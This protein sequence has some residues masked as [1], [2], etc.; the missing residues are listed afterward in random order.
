MH[1]RILCITSGRPLAPWALQV[2]QV[3]SS[4]PGSER[5]QRQAFHRPH[6]D[7]RSHHIATPGPVR[8]PVAAQR[9]LPAARPQ[10]SDRSRPAPWRRGCLPAA[11]AVR[12]P[13][14]SRKSKG[15]PLSAEQPRAQG[16]KGTGSR[17]RSGKDP[18]VPAALIRE[19][20][21]LPPLSAR[22]RVC[23]LFRLASVSGGRLSEG[24]SFYHQ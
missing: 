5:K 18:F 22:L 9:A 8:G 15:A 3:K 1:R 19:W 7:L 11:G 24:R 20:L 2:P 10:R 13:M 12:R 17:V 21:K 4:W 14:R 23:R 6:F 16:V